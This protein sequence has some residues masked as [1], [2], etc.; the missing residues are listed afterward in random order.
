[1]TVILRKEKKTDMVVYAVAFNAKAEGCLG[2]S[3]QSAKK[4]VWGWGLGAKPKITIPV[5][6]QY[7]QPL[8]MQWKMQS[9]F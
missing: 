4:R 3:L 2:A 7:F 1:M 5:S 8:S 6:S 9:P